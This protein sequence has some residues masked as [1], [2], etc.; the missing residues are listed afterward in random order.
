M[1]RVVLLLCFVLIACSRSSGQKELNFIVFYQSAQHEVPFI[2][3]DIYKELDPSG[4]VSI[5]YRAFNNSESPE[6]F[7]LNCELKGNALMASV[8]NQSFF[9]L[10]P[11]AEPT[12]IQCDP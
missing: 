12:K 6:E 2:F 1:P 4:G 7:H 5:N 3:E 8:D 9:S 10:F 11:A